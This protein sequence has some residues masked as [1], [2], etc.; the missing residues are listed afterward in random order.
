MGWTPPTGFN[1]PSSKWILEYSAYDENTATYAYTTY[2][3][4]NQ[5]WLE[6]THAALDCTKVRLMGYRIWD[7]SHGSVMVNADIYYAGDWHRVASNLVL[8]EDTWKEIEFGQ[9]S[10]TA[11]RVMCGNYAGG[12]FRVQEAAFWETPVV[13]RS[14]GYVIG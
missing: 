2:V 5:G 12:Q 9:Q 7:S 13:G 10:V 11:L 4:Y 6:L 3:Y 14:F 8:E 1:D